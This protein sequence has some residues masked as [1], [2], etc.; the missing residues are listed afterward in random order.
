MNLLFTS[1]ESK[2][3]LFNTRKQAIFIQQVEIIQY[4]KKQAI[5]VQN[6]RTTNL[7]PPFEK[8]T[9]TAFLKKR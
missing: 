5:F 2:Q 3:Y 4:K 9:A 6:T 1:Q 8:K 7:T